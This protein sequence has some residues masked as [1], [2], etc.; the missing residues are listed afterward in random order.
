MEK[1][2][3]EK[4]LGLLIMLASTVASIFFIARIL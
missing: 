4:A 2:N 1:I 3:K